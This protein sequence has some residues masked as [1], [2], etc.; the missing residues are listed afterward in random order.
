MY[1]KY[2]NTKYIISIHIANDPIDNQNPI[3]DLDLKS[4]FGSFNPI[5]ARIKPTTLPI[6][7]KG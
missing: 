4:L 3:L 5:N 7:I 6:N 2:P 1:L